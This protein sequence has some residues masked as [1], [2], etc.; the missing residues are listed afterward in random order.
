MG[1]TAALPSST[2]P[3]PSSTQRIRS[4]RG[5]PKE[6]SGTLG[7]HAATVEFTDF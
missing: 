3:L 4:E 1:C 5:P 6:G 7:V 2:L